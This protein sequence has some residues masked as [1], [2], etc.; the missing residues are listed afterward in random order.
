MTG[1][2]CGD[3]AWPAAWP[4]AEAYRSD[5]VLN[6]RDDFYMVSNYAHFMSICFP[7]RGQDP[8]REM[9]KKRAEN[10]G[11]MKQLMII[12]FLL[13]LLVTPAAAE[14][15]YVKGD[16]GANLRNGN[17]TRHA[18]IDTID[19]GQALLA[20]ET[21][22][23]WTKVRL[24]DG[25]EGWMASRL[26]TDKKPAA[27]IASELNNK[28][29]NLSIESESIQAENERLI[30]ENQSLHEKLKEM[31]EQMAQTREAHETLIAESADFLALKA[32]L[33]RLSDQL[34]E[35]TEIIASLEAELAITN[36]S[37]T[38]HWFLAG[39]GVLL[40]GMIIGAAMKRRRTKFM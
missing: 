27:I 21:C 11:Y 16:S 3:P 22:N 14:T 38:I 4:P 25:K 5:F 35:K 36:R 1:H 37:A 12:G 33:E 28:I 2:G 17:S 32:D 39:A 19:P 23:K 20:I 18:V 7:A 26:L 8:P 34:R 13:V 15:L 31:F 30:I 10:A 29:E 24:P 9:L 6:N 40:L